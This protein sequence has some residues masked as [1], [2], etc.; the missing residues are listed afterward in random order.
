MSLQLS[1]PLE[2]GVRQEVSVVSDIE[3]DE[4][5]AFQVRGARH[6]GSQRPL[7]NA[8]SFLNLPDQQQFVRPR[9]ITSEDSVPS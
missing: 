3:M 6:T 5:K 7:T 1:A 9:A 4:Q 8:G 2:I